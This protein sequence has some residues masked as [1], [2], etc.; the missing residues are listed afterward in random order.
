MEKFKAAIETLGCRVNIY[1]SEAMKE[2]LQKEDYEIVNFSEKADVYIINTCT[3]TAMGDKKSRQLVGR[4]KN[5]NENAIIALVGCYAQVSTEEI[6]KMENI[7]I[8]LGSRDKS[9]IA[10]AIE[11]FKATGEK[12]IEVS[13]I[14]KE[15]LFEDLDISSFKDHTRAFLKVQDGCDRFCSYCMIPYARGAASSKSRMK[16]LSEIKVLRDH[17]FKEIILTGIHIASYGKD[18]KDSD[19]NESDDNESEKNQNNSLILKK[20]K[21]YDLMDLLEDIEKIEGIERIRIGSIEPGFITEDRIKRMAK[22]KKLLPH[23]HL[24]LQSGSDTVLK[25]M[26]RKYSSNEYEE[27][28]KKLREHIPNVSI[29]TDI[30]VGFPGETEEEFNETKEF[31][32]RIKLSHI[33][34]FSYSERKGTPAAKMKNKIPKEIKVK[35]HEIVESISRKY[36][37]QFQEKMI[38]K[39]YKVLIE[40]EKDEYLEGYTENYMAVKLMKKDLKNENFD[41]LK[42][43]I[44]KVKIVRI[45]DSLIGELV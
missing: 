14:M 31:L 41:T 20:E 9:K 39:T 35:R 37:R 25:R 10:Y 15:S 22:L 38:G 33:H 34:V 5:L 4:A 23:Y 43:S 3:V 36:H 12:V 2:I 8:V 24:S 18:F 45:V 28:C 29:T 11:K 44:R 40:A 16:A 26:N 1:D 19:D 21:N 6:S 27:A 32:E 7:D 17:G 13:E 30:I 42:N